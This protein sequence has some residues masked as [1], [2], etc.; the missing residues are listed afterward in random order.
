[1]YISF[2]DGTS[3][4]PFQLNLP[5]VPITDLTIK[6]DNLIAATQGRSFWLI[7]DLT[8]LHQLNDAVASSDVTL[9]K[10]MPSYRMAGG[11]SFRVPKN[12]G[13]N[14]PGGVMIHYYLK[15]TTKAQVSLEIMEHNGKLIKKYATKPD[16]KAKEEMLRVKPGANRFVWN[17]RYPDAESFDGLIMWAGSVV[18]PKAVPGTYKAKLTVNGKS[19]E[20]EFEILKDPR[21]SGTLADIQQQFQFLIEV[22][23]KLSET[24]LAVKRIRTSREQI[25]RVIDPMKGKEDMKDVTDLAKSILDDMKKIEEALYQTKNRS[26]QD[27]LNYPV[28]LNNKLAALAGEADG[29]DYRPT[30]QVKAVQQEITGK[31]DDQLQQLNVIF[32]NQLPKLNELVKQKQINPVTLPEPF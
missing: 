27:P 26:G 13:K 23:D 17:M 32:K 7:D 29:G 1:M 22:R 2:D 24:N 30:Q 15:D 3:W 16:K 4:K 18:G 21:T 20:T 5:I 14:H 19:Q 11:F 8:P 28:R 25:N 12:E 9:F 6:N 10:P 31:I